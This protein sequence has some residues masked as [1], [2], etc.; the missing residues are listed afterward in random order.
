MHS[1]PVPASLH[2]RAEE[3]AAVTAA[4]ARALAGPRRLVVVTGTPG[5]GR[6][7]FLDATAELIAEGGFVVLRGGGSRLDHTLP[8]AVVRQILARAADAGA[9]DHAFGPAQEPP[10]DE[11]LATDEPGTLFTDALNVSGR[12]AAHGPVAIVMDD[13]QWADQPSLEWLAGLLRDHGPT[14]LLLVA[15]VR[16]GDPAA[17]LPVVQDLVA[18][19]D[20][21]VPLR[22]LTAEGVR[23]L[24]RERAVTL[25]GEGGRAWARAT[26]GNPTLVNSLFDRLGGSPGA[27]P[28][29]LLDAARALPAPWNLRGRVAATLSSHPEPVRRFAYCAAILGGAAEDRLIARLAGVDPA[30]RAAAAW[31][32]RRLGWAPDRCEPPV[33]W[34]CVR[35]IAEDSYGPE[36]WGDLHRRSATLL[37]ESGYPLERVATHLLEV[38]PGGHTQA[39]DVLREAA[40]DARRRGDRHLAIRYLRR[41]L[42]EFPPGSPER[43]RFLA[44]LADAEQDVDPSALLRHIAQAVALLPSAEERAAV[45]AGVPLTLSLSASPVAYELIA[46]AR[47]TLT[48]DEGPDSAARELT[49][50]LEARARLS[51]LGSPTAPL[52]A[53][54]RLRELGPELDLCSA[55]R[56]ERAAVLTFAGTIGCRLSA[57]EAGALARRMLEREPASAPS[58]YAA[59]SLM[60][61]SGTA[62]EAHDPVRSWLDMAVEAAHRRGD[63]RQRIRMLCGRAMAAQQGGRLADA[64][65]DARDACDETTGALGESDWLSALGLLSVAVELRDPWLSERA[66]ALCADQRGAGVPILRVGLLA[67]RAATTRM[68]Q[69]PALTK[70]LV[71]AVRRAG[72]SGWHNPSLFPLAYWSTPALLRLGDNETALE[73]IAH[74]CDRARTWGS[75]STLGRTLRVWG[76][77]VPGRYALSLLAE[78]VAVLRESPNEL[79]LARALMAYAMRLRGAGRAGATELLA[80]AERIADAMG[81]SLL[82][83]WAE[84]G[85]G[86]TRRAGLLGTERLSVTERRVAG[87]VALG[88]T[89]QEVAEELDV[90]RRAVEKCL[91]RLYRRL[92]VSS[93]AELI[94]VVRR[95]AGANA[96]RWGVPESL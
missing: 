30:D 48:S 11:E 75:P 37:H 8:Y 62:A 80:E 27:A 36:G 32:L 95:I 35:E 81:E 88:R 41:A 85:R 67:L 79:E 66:Q 76:T 89:N 83:Y 25:P 94:P 77:L 22:P 34:D 31:A 60:I 28:S 71:A 49:A 39:A 55:A 47:A 2:D 78:S 90:T 65:A 59:A 82:R 20:D 16:D 86:E 17:E 45:V 61:A 44:A 87:L 53:V 92:G 33:L 68:P 74:E 12:A 58:G 43:G 4:T 69:L 7:A 40:D 91:T 64:W 13:A 63:E 50:R 52:D 73:L 96:F 5:V 42:R 57:E 70:E 54:A 23:A 15:A 9:R 18:I 84:P 24:L 19:A 56:R 3:L 29:R 51:E 6:S 26:G 38:G 72:A 10:T 93:R 14:P 1:S 21:I 46:S